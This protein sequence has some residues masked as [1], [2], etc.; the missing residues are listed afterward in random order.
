MFLHLVRRIPYAAQDRSSHKQPSLLALSTS[1]WSAHQTSAHA[2]APGGSWDLRTNLTAWASSIAFRPGDQLVFSYD[3]SAHDVVEV[4]RDGYLSCS[5]QR[6]VSAARMTGSETIRLDGAGERYFICGAPG[7]CAAG[8]KLRVRVS[9]DAACA[10]TSPPPSP[11]GAPSR[12]T[13]CYG[14]PPPN[15]TFNV[16][17]RV[18]PAGASAAPGSSASLSSVAVTV[19]SL[20]LVGLVIVLSS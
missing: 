15:T 10:G 7:H 17:P 2:G 5:V 12:F 9:G 11:P 20:L 8:M 13:I 14:S 18:K 16:A 3:A 4:T 1:S 19:V 6:P